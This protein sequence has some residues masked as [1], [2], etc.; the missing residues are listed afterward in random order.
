MSTTTTTR[1]IGAGVYEIDTP[2]GTFDVIRDHFTNGTGTV[3]SITWPGRRIPDAQTA[4]LF[5]AKAIVRN[6]VDPVIPGLNG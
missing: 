2:I 5:D 3:W 1:R 6:E 4:T